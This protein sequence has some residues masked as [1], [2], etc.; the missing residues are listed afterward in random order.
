[1]NDTLTKMLNKTEDL[2]VRRTKKWLQQA[3][4]ELM[5]E[6]PFRSLQI[7]EIA[8]RAEVSR[9]TFYLHF[10]SK[11]ELLLSLVDLSFAEF[12]QELLT[13][14]P[15]GQYSKLALCTQLFVQWQRH[16][17]TFTLIVATDLQQEVVE[18]M[19]GYLKTILEYLQAQ[20]GKPLASGDAFELMVGFMANG[21]YA[22]LVEWATKKLPYTPEQ[23]GM[24]LHQLTISHEEIVMPGSLLIQNIEVK[25]PI[26]SLS[27]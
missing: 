22:L 27:R 13:S 23:M 7:S 2:R 3:L 11:E 12:F 24:F 21:A 1:M 18:R 6:K 17:D 4:V 26:P 10:A 16:Q 19:R 9:P 20:T 25:T 5:R 15:Q 8:S 14:L